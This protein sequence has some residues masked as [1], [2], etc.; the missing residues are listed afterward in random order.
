MGMIVDPER[1]NVRG[2]D[3]I[4][5]TDDSPVTLCVVAADEEACIA[6]EAEAVIN[7]L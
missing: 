1:N 6:R 5:S 4:I 7:G 2:Q 3:T